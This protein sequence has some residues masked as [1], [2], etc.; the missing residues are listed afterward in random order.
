MLQ[1]ANSRS[2]ASA[3]WTSAFARLRFSGTSELGL[4]NADP[5]AADRVSPGR[6]VQFWFSEC[7]IHTVASALITSCFGS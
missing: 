3:T 2:P 1:E 7:L 5:V 4:C 6:L